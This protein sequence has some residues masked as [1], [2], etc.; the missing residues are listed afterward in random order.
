MPL[1]STVSMTDLRVWCLL[2]DHEKKA[3][4]GDVFSV[5]VPHDAYVDDL[6]TKIK[7]V[8]PVALGHVNRVMLTA[9]EAPKAIKKED[10]DDGQ[11]QISEG[12]SKKRKLLWET[13]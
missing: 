11:E 12:R 4:F 6:K 9:E 13:D 1:A 2:I 3:A 10:A 8:R 7:E 5:K